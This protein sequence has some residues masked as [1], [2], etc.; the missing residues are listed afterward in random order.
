MKN[1]E[2]TKQFTASTSVLSTQTSITTKALK[3]IQTLKT[4]R[5]NSVH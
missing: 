2:T 5:C 1:F 3:I 4:S